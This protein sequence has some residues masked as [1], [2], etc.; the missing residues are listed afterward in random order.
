MG[1]QIGQLAIPGDLY[2]VRSDKIEKPDQCRPTRIAFRQQIAA[3]VILFTRLTQTLPLQ[4]AAQILK[5][6]TQADLSFH[7]SA[8]PGTH[9]CP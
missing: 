3:E 8:L 6:P 4:F 5:E 9:G 1:A 7:I 2:R